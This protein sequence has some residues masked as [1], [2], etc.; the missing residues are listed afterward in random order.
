MPNKT[1]FYSKYYQQIPNGYKSINTNLKYYLQALRYY[2]M[3]LMKFFLTRKYSFCDSYQD[4]N[5]D[6]TEEILLNYL[7]QSLINFDLV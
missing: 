3:P 5:R 4:M 2:S 6:I 7:N 1:I